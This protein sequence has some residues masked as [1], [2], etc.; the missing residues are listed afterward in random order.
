[1]PFFSEI[2]V[3]F[4][5]CDPVVLFLSW[6]MAASLEPQARR[7]SGRVWCPMGT[8]WPQATSQSHAQMNFLPFRTPRNLNFSSEKVEQ[9]REEEK[10]TVSAFDNHDFIRMQTKKTSDQLL[11]N[12]IC[13]ISPVLLR[14][15][16][17]S[18]GR[19]R[20]RALSESVHIWF[21][22][23]VLTIWPQLGFCCQAKT[24]HFV[25]GV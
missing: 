9:K 17:I 22:H 4:L 13:F 7:T 8:Q 25:A 12:S 5:Q 3:F 15:P 19:G 23:V 14:K 6:R 20:G 16:Q 2:C 11:F 18:S 21:K 10:Q 1:M 24:H